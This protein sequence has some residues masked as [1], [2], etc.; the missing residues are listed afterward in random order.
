V[1]YS[2]VHVAEVDAKYDEMLG[3]ATPMT[4]YIVDTS[5]NGKG[6]NDMSA[7]AGAPYNQPS[8]V[9]AGLRAASWCN[10]PGAGAGP[11]PTSNTGVPLAAAY[12]WVKTPGQSDGSCDS[13]GGARPWDY[14]AYNPWGLTDLAAQSHFDP[15]WG[16]ADPAAGAWF[17]Q[18]AL[19][20]ARLAQPP[21]LP[22]DR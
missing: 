4:R 14:S 13:A 2:P 8:D 17:P 5:R 21:L 10:P 9:V 6:P 16:T 22:K 7:F 12:L 20:L 11:R 3:G 19:E 1:D 15:L 18:Q